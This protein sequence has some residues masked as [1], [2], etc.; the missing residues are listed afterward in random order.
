MQQNGSRREHHERAHAGAIRA[1]ARVPPGER[2]LGAH[3]PDRVRGRGA[4]PSG[5]G[6]G[7]GARHR[8]ARRCRRP[9]G[10]GPTSAGTARQTI[11]ANRAVQLLSRLDDRLLADIGLRR[12]DIEL[13]V[14]G[15]LADPR[16]P[17][18][19]GAGGA[20]ARGQSA[21]RCRR[22]PANSNQP[23]LATTRSSTWPPDAA[24]LAGSSA[25]EGAI[26]SV[27]AQVDQPVDQGDEDRRRPRCCRA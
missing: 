7:R 22:A 6:Y 10:R 2:L 23:A 11:R 3:R 19:R 14:D 24:E 17:A 13:A 26:G 27:A 4:P 12:A 20:T 18:P 9:R 5:A 16:V 8:L 15:R 21:G 1:L 25:C